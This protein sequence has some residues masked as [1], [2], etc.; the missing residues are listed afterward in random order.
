M[1][2]AGR[3]WLHVLGLSKLVWAVALTAIQRGIQQSCAEPFTVSFDSATPLLWAGKYQ[4][5][6]VPPR[7]TENI[8]TWRMASLPFPVGF[9]A[10]TSR[11]SDPFPKGSPLSARLTLGDVN[12]KTDPYSEQTLSTFGLQAL[13]NHN[14]YVFLRATIDAN[15]NALTSGQAPEQILA[16]TGA[17]AELLSCEA[18]ADKLF[19][20]TPILREALPGAEL[21]S[22]G[23]SAQAATV[24]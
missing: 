17:I 3:K 24:G 22:T 23:T 21:T 6:A 1:L 13:S 19:D 8:D 2:G 16:M 7:L 20:I 18:W 14:L 9:A 11:A 5:Y 4:K 15:H 12:T 10:A